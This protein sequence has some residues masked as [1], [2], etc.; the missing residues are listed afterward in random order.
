MSLKRSYTLVAPF[1]DAFLTA[2][3][4]GAR[5]R[6]LSALAEGSPRDVLLLG[7]GTGLDLPHLPPQH[8]Y[9]GLDLT[10]AMLM[11]A[12]PRAAGLR[13]AALR[14]D[15]Q[16]LPFHDASFDAAV[17]HLILAVVPAPTLCLAEAVRVVKPGGSLLVFDKF[18]RR[19]EAGWKRLLNPLTRHV[20]TRLDVVFED[21]LDAVGGISVTSNE[22]AMASGWFRLIR[23]AKHGA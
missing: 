10:A 3:T 8:R 23:I 13:F 16:R 1:Y 6:S 2:A 20:A 17:L 5:K 4:H 21:L 7:V 18:M 9:V 14:G 22:A 11:R 15:V 19:G 12:R